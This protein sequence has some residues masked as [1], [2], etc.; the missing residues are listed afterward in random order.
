MNNLSRKFIVSGRVQGVGF[1]Y[2]TCHE[3]LKQGLSGYAKNLTNGDVEVVANGTEAALNVFYSWLK[4]GP[5]TSAVES[6]EMLEIEFQHLS[7][8]KIKY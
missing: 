5:S 7:G 2:H 4:Q 3:G 6:V 1:R 8:F